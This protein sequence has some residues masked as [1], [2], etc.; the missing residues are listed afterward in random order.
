MEND[1]CSSGW[2]NRSTH[3]LRVKRDSASSCALFFDQ[4]EANG[5]ARFSVV[6]RYR[7]TNERVSLT[8][9]MP[10]NKWRPSDV[11][12]LFDFTARYPEWQRTSD[13]ETLFPPFRI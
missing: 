2:C 9:G 13:A 1:S 7:W 3:G 8:N 10:S 5:W 11:E 4:L 12:F 6:C